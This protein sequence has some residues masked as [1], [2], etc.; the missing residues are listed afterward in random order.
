MNHFYHI[1]NVNIHPMSRLFLLLFTLFIAF[2]QQA[3]TQVCE[4]DPGL[5][6]ADPGLYP[7]P[8]NAGTR[9]GGGIS[10]A[11]CAGMPYEFTFT[12]IAADSIAVFQGGAQNRVTNVTLNNVSVLDPDGNASS[13]EALG[14]SY[15]CNPGSCE[16]AG[17]SSGCLHI[18]GTVP[19]TVTPGQYELIFRG[20]TTIENIGTVN[21][22]LPDQTNFPGDTY[23]L[24]VR[25]TE[26][27]PLN[28]DLQAEVSVD[29]ATCFSS[30]DGSAT[31]TT[32]GATGTVTY[33]WDEG[34]GSQTTA[35]ATNLNQGSYRV[36]VSDE[37]GC[38][39]ELQANVG[40]GIGVVEFTVNK[41]SD[42]GCSEGGQ[43]T[44]VIV[45]GV[46]PFQ[47]TWSDD[48]TRND[49][50]ATN[51][52]PGE[53]MVTVTDNTGCTA[54]DRVTIESVGT[55]LEITLT[56]TDV[57]CAGDNTGTATV[58]VEGGNEG[59]TFLWSNNETT[60]T[61]S[62]LAADTYEVTVTK[63]GCEVIE[64]VVINEGDPL[65]LEVFASLAVC[66]GNSD[67]TATATA[68]G[69]SG[70]YTYAWSGDG[71]TADGSS[72]DNLPS[73]DYEVLVTDSNGCSAMESFT[74]S[75]SAPP[76]GFTIID[77]DVT[78]NGLADGLATL[79][80]D[81]DT[82]GL[83]VTWSTGAT[84][85][86][87]GGL[88]AGDYSVTVG[89]SGCTV[90]SMFDIAEPAAIE[91]NITSTNISCDFVTLGE[92]SASPAGGSGG[93]T[94]NW[95]N[96][97]TDASQ[98]GV[99]AGQYILT[100]TDSDG[101]FV[102]DT[103]EVVIEQLEVQT[104]VDIE[105]VAC[106]GEATGGATVNILGGD[107]GFDFLWSTG[108][109]TN[110]IENRTAGT[111]SF[112]ITD[113]RGCEY[114]DSV[115]ITEPTAIE[116]AFDQEIASADCNAGL[117][118]SLTAMASG[119]TG[120]LTY[121]WSTGA[122]IATINELETATYVVTVTDENACTTIDSIAITTD[123]NAFSVS[124]TVTEITCSGDSDGMIQILASGGSGNY[125]YEWS[126]PNVTSTALVNNLSAGM[127]SVTISDNGAC[128]DT[129]SIT[130]ADPAPISFET[131]I[132]SVSCGG[133]TDGGFTLTPTGGE[134]PYAYVWAHSTSDTSEF[135]NL[136]AGSYIFTL[137]DANACS[138][139]D[140]VLVTEP[141][142]IE[143][144]TRSI[145]AGC[146][147]QLPDA[148]EATV[149]GG[150][151]NYRYMWSNGILSPT[152]PNPPANTYTLV[153]TDGRNCVDSIQVVVDDREVP[154][155]LSS[156][157]TNVDCNDDGSN[158]GSATV[159][160]EGGSGSYTYEWSNDETTPAISDLRGGT[161]TVTVSDD[162][163]C[164]DSLSIEVLDP[165]RFNVGLN[166]NNVSCFGDD[167]G[168]VLLSTSRGTVDDFIYV[169][170]DNS[171]QS[172]QPSRTGLA[173][174]TYTVTVTELLTGCVIVESVDVLEP[175]EIEI[176]LSGQRNVSCA[177][178]LD[179][180]IEVNV[181]GGA[182]VLTVEWSN[183]SDTTAVSGLRPGEQT[184]T[185]TDRNRCEATATFTITEPEPVMVSV[186]AT[187]QITG[188]D[189]TAVANAMGGTAPYSYAWLTSNGTP[190][191]TS[192]D[193]VGG[194]FSGQ[195]TLI[196]TDAN[197]CE[198]STSFEIGSSEC[199]G[200]V[201]LRFETEPADCIG[202]LGRA[203]VLATGGDAP[204]TYVWS[205]GDS[206]TVTDSLVAGIYDIT[207]TDSQG[208]PAF[209][210]IEIDDPN[211]NV[212][213]AVDDVTCT[214]AADGSI[215]AIPGGP[216]PFTY[217]WSTGDT[218]QIINDLMPGTYD[219][220][221]TN[222]LGCSNEVSALV[223]EGGGAGALE[224]EI[225][226]RVNVS[227]PGDSD[228]STSIAATGGEGPYTFTWEQEGTGDT[229]MGDSL[230]NLA[231]GIYLVTTTDDNGCEVATSV[232]ISEPD[233]IMAEV[234]VN[235]L[236]CATDSSGTAGVNVLG[237]G[238][239]PF[240]YLWST[241]D[242]TQGV[243]GL[244][245]GM[246]STT[247][248]DS[249]GCTVAYEFEI[250]A[251]D[252]IAIEIVEI[253]NET[254]AGA[255]DGT[256]TINVSGGNSPYTYLWDN[257]QNTPTAT[258]LSPGLHTVTVTDINGCTATA[259]VNINE[260]GCSLKAN[261][262]RT[263]ITCNG[264]NDGTA[265]ASLESSAGEL[266]FEWSNRMETATIENLEPGTYVV[267]V[268]DET[269]CTATD[270]ITIDEPDAVQVS[271]RNVID[272]DC[273]GNG[274]EAT[275]TGS[276]GTGSF[277]YSW[278]SG[279][280]T[281]TATDLMMGENSVT[282]T[283]ENGC[284]VVETVDIVQ[285]SG[286][287]ANVVPTAISCNGEADGTIRVDV[288]GNADDFTFDF[289]DGI[290][291]DGNTASGL[292]AGDYSVVVSDANG[293]SSTFD[294]TIGGATLL[295]A[296]ANVT[297]PIICKGDSSAVINIETRGGNRSY[298]YAW[299]DSDMRSDSIATNLPADEYIITVTDFNGCETT[300]EVTI[301]EPDDALT[302]MIE[303]SNE[304]D[305]DANDG[306][307]RVTAQGGASDDYRYEWNDPNGTTTA[308]VTGLAPGDYS[309]TVTDE[310]GCEI[311]LN[312]TIEAAE[313]ACP[314]YSIEISGRGT[315]CPATADGRAEVTNISNEGESTF[316]YLWSNGD[317][318][319]VAE[320]LETGVVTVTI[321][322]ELG[323]M[324]EASVTIVPTDSLNLSADIA[325]VGCAG[326]GDG[327]ANINVEGGMAPYSY[328]WGIDTLGGSMRGTLDMGNYTVVV[329]DANG[330]AS[331]IDFDIEMGEDNTAPVI[332]VRELTVYLDEF[333]AAN[334]EM[335]SLVL[336][337][338]DNCGLDSTSIE[339]VQFDCDNVG[340]N[341]VLI[342]ALDES[343]NLAELRAPVMVLDTTAPFLDCLNQDTLITD[344]LADR[345]INFELPQVLDNCGASLTP[346]LVSGLESGSVFPPGL[347][348]QMFEVMDSSG[349]V[350]TCTFMVDIDVL[351][352]EIEVNEPTCF[353]FANGAL[354]ARPVNATGDVFYEW[355]DGT[356]DSTLLGLAGGTYMVTVIDEVGCSRIEEVTL[357][358]PDLLTVE[359]DSFQRATGDEANAAI[360][361]TVE[362]GSQP[363]NYQWTK[364]GTELILDVEDLINVEFGEYRLTVFDANGCTV[365]SEIVDTPTDEVTANY[366]VQVQP[367]PTSGELFVQVEQPTASPQHYAL[368]DM[369]GRLVRQWEV[370][371]NI[372]QEQTINLSSY[373]DGIY[374]LRIQID[375]DILTERIVLMR[376]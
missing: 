364:D 337:I 279:E 53:Y 332:E 207:V 103:T 59:A 280:T 260:D 160:V 2:Q 195:Y 328:N 251:P 80:F 349:N 210:T 295:E 61:I 221:I 257:D 196:V 129:L 127:Y 148:V 8:F 305:L 177:G 284:S 128:S 222:G 65:L 19:S 90:T 176:T 50:I 259:T 131:T 123:G 366:S 13:L 91:T 4:P 93:Y 319:A 250:L 311:V 70:E 188:S 211:F 192:A 198:G 263:N 96:D 48:A 37:T 340:M 152:L 317:T 88:E 31:V 25:G 252:S 22:N 329:T 301:T 336:S 368:Y 146:S 125:E 261:L 49:S 314:T 342:R 17:G 30:S 226:S 303:S 114:R 111:Y 191:G 264:A 194:L 239:A 254:V 204:Y 105:E 99:G 112:L 82:T 243:F 310:N 219:V 218:T 225:T 227:C 278:S 145:G 149:T 42:A 197:G 1:V 241:G 58:T 216:S 289:G 228:G 135:S 183:G 118:L 288:I 153:V 286:I 182:G 133:A 170:S 6:N 21:V 150:D 186:N 78:C 353:G 34:A 215:T 370:D 162:T 5:A 272:L 200:V 144:V 255:D 357:T 132:E 29:A 140:S 293:C 346:A 248:T 108:D 43:A 285:D 307:A 79:L 271:I 181:E 348:E 41:D 214:G 369:T 276:G 39:I 117:P 269:G 180:F 154:L 104:A 304:T 315:S 213:L 110:A 47:Y 341:E 139:V 351:G 229:F 72:I 294:Y 18:S 360:F 189:G 134:A 235:S 376:N 281:A 282:I 83:I 365:V 244:G 81:G 253:T 165:G 230:T 300:V 371:G 199:A 308:T 309:V 296:M 23:F 51:L 24:E 115:I 85:V 273:E 157:V 89:L 12:L 312:T 106:N 347:T 223:E 184:I 266:T 164:L 141:E 69:G 137:T 32:T 231:V 54:E 245:A 361:V 77:G 343:G 60:A 375:N 28:C 44:V 209:G 94:F 62:N 102:V 258:D 20:T 330:C 283:D 27:V 45:S 46:P 158:N 35:T 52:T 306:R 167:N 193:S 322:D 138:V 350:A 73:G 171:S 113:S 202:G 274:G 358:E 217:E 313:D 232:E 334:F 297:S 302:A 16:V 64:S 109:V 126:I 335:D 238:T 275:A 372:R 169:W 185:V 130:L 331:M 338:T 320:N 287:D 67:G 356:R 86:S 316:T 56:S 100:V 290:T 168:R 299:S 373:D 11:A 201:D 84:G 374:L 159:I 240:T 33:Q 68:T 10:E 124:S 321:T 292:A 249:R 163:G 326:G 236:T 277:A 166:V 205:T 318:T 203:S 270:Q 7:P 175:E 147:G 116:I 344:C 9:P 178:G 71:F 15:A 14:L 172:N 74:I 267:T 75:E 367:N 63:E 324:G 291:S 161:Y 242:S 208:C 362:G 206:T 363:Y 121:N 234:L 155:E 327:R 40:T 156:T 268:S 98:F 246:G 120:A 179:G 262:T 187:D 212:T 355:G 66:E 101:C 142:P 247:I 174:G 325:G 151:G 107:A 76:P 3:H 87:V 339:M 92:V 173:G 36:T 122:T 298:D 359:I 97:N 224:S 143:I 237:G 233:S 190:L 57:A 95:S 256:A 354:L 220:T 26:C 136:M 119:G 352:V 55:A 333:G 345:T 38:E 323:C 265:T